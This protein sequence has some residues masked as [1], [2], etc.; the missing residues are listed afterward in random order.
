MKLTGTVQ[1][2]DVEG[3]TWRLQADDGKHYV[4]RGGDRKLKKNGARIEAEGQ[5]DT[6]S[7]SLEMQG[8]L[9]VVSR[10]SFL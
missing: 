3:G 8:P 2:V 5:V 6:S 1:F 9:F 4:L 7:L 10:Y